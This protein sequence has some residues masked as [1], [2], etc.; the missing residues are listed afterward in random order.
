LRHLTRFDGLANALGHFQDE[1]DIAQHLLDLGMGTALTG[2]VLIL[3][4]IPF[5]REF[6]VEWDVRRHVNLRFL[7][8]GSDFVSPL[9]I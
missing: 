7:I 2:G 1:S 5:D 4:I 3:P 8:A 9:V 6:P